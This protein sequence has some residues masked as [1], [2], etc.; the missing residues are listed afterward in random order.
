MEPTGAYNSA[1]NRLVERGIG[2]LCVWAQLCLYASGLEVTY[3]CF[4][5]SHAAMLCSFRPQTKT[6]VSSHEAFLKKIPNYSNPAIWGS[7]VYVVNRCLTR[8]CPESATIT[9]CF[10]GYAGSHH[11]IAYRNDVTGA[12]QLCYHT[13]IDELDLKTLPGDRGPAAQYLAGII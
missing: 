6:N 7:P 2:V 8:R 9:G 3:W 10:L 13:A 11:I 4:T 1:A 12:I 5:V